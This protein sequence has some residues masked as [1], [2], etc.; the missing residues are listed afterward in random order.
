MSLTYGD[1]IPTLTYEPTVDGL[2][3]GDLASILLFGGIG[4]WAVVAMAAINRAGPWTR[5]TD[6][7]GV[8]G[9]VMNLV[10][11]VVLYAIIAGIHFW[12]GHN[13]F[14]GTFA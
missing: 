1:P 10:G 5:P 9:D 8:K 11:T 2:V 13:P 14:L 3:N 4:L 7:R 12:L 6:G